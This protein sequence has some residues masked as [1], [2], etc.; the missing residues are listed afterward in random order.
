DDRAVPGRGRLAMGRDGGVREGRTTPI[1]GA[2]QTRLQRLA[3]DIRSQHES[4]ASG[5]KLRDVVRVVRDQNRA[6][7]RAGRKGGHILRRN[8]STVHSSGGSS[9]AGHVV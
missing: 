6:V 5:N 8:K 9:D 7:G 1:D 4:T 2:L 3:T